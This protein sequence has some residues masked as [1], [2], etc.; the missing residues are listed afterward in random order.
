MGC[1]PTEHT[2]KHLLLLLVVHLAIT[3]TT[4]AEC[5]PSILHL[6]AETLDTFVLDAGVVVAQVNLAVQLDAGVRELVL[7]A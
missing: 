1:T 2:N 4:V 7:G 3:T 6:G 5:V